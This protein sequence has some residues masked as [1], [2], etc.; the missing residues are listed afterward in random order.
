MRDLARLGALVLA[1]LVAGRNLAVAGASH[2]MLV[3]TG[4]TLLVVVAGLTLW[5]DGLVTGSGVALAAHYVGS[6]GYG[7]VV[8]DLGAPVVGALIV[9]Y[10]DLA[11]LAAS[12]PRDRRVDRALLLRSLKRTGGVIGAGVVAGAAAYGVAAVPWPGGELLR[13]AGA[14]GV[15][16]VVVV[17][18]YLLRRAQ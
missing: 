9:A 7:D 10:L 12:V 8:L 4:I 6:L 18:V 11:D 5:R 2:A 16:A 15:A 17:P 3:A 14:L 1:L 13:A